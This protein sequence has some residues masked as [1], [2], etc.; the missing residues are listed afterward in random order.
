MRHPS[1]CRKSIPIAVSSAAVVARSV[2]V[3]ITNAAAYNCSTIRRS[4][5]IRS[6][7]VVIVA[8]RI[9]PS[10]IVAGPILGYVR[11]LCTAAEQRCNSA[12]ADDRQKECS[13]AAHGFRFSYRLHQI[14]P[15]PLN[16]AFPSTSKPLGFN[17]SCA[18]LR[19]LLRFAYPIRR[20]QAS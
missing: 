3:V 13:T 6:G 9:V 2:S 11:A 4:V 20:Q 8:G 1:A 17:R 10:R 14:F 19:G 16:S 5:F 12:C 18:L 7:V 15:F